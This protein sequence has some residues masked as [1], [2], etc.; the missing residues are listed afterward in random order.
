MG[1]HSQCLMLASHTPNWN[2]ILAW[3]VSSVSQPVKFKHTTRGL[4]IFL[5]FGPFQNLTEMFQNVDIPLT[6]HLKFGLSTESLLA[7]VLWNLL[8]LHIF[9]KTT[10]D[11][12][13]TSISSDTVPTSSS[14]G[15]LWVVLGLVGIFIQSISVSLKRTAMSLSIYS[16]RLYS[17]YSCGS[18]L[19]QPHWCHGKN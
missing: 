1:Q 4:V 7:I 13:G 8:I 17:I 15:S 11:A 14:M 19:I 16:L 6:E 5:P 9:L 10:S 3:P 2:L 18:S 12:T